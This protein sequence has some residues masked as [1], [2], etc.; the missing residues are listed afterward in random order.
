MSRFPE[1]TDLRKMTFGFQK[2]RE[3]ILKYGNDEEMGLRLSLP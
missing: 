3:G 2:V 1:S